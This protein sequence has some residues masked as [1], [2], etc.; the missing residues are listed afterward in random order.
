MSA[1]RSLLETLAGYAIIAGTAA[2]MLAY[3]AV[4]A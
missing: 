4:F 3:A 1:P 2:A